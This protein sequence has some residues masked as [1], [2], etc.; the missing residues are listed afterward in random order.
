MNIKVIKDIESYIMMFGIERIEER[1]TSISE[2][3]KFL[4]NCYEAC[5]SRIKKCN[6]EDFDLEINQANGRKL[7]G[8][9]L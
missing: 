1:C 2:D 9:V 4:V 8:D 6:Y 5:I 7:L 3:T